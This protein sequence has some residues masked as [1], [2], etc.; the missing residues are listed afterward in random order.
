MMWICNLY[1]CEVKAEVQHSV[2]RCF[3]I[4]QSFLEMWRI[5]TTSPLTLVTLSDTLCSLVIRLPLCFFLLSL[6]IFEGNK[7]ARE[8]SENSKSDRISVSIPWDPFPPSLPPLPLPSPSLSRG[9]ILGQNP[10]QSLKSF[11][12]CFSQSPLQLCLEISI[13]LNSRNLLQF[14]Q[15]SYCTY[16]VKETGGKSDLKPFRFPMV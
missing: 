9:W 10:D 7:R 13:S 2:H 15:F 6:S 14:L 8:K 5:N 4:S 3:Y 11:P 16:T 1:M 12:P